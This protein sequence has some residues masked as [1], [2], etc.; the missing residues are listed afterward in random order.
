STGDMQPPQNLYNQVS[1]QYVGT[2]DFTIN[3]AVMSLPVDPTPKPPAA[4]PPGTNPNF[5]LG[6]LGWN[7]PD[8]INFYRPNRNDAPFGP[9][10]LE[11]LYRSQDIDGTSLTSRLGDLAPISFNH[12][13]EKLT[14]RR[15]FSVETWER[16]NFVF[17][18]DNPDGV[19]FANNSR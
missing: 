15:T 11:W 2:Y 14:R 16:N 5:P 12:P 7:D 8:E 3:S 9:T 10:D 6:S 18:H 13:V 4:D 17:A 1:N 19:T